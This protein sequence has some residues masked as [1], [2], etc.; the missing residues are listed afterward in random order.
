MTGHKRDAL[1]AAVAAAQRGWPVFP[2]ERGGKRPAVDRW[3]QRA[4]T[5]LEVIERAWSG[6]WSGYNIGIPSGRAGLAVLDLDCHAGLP[7]DWRAIPGVKDGAD[8]FACLLEWAGE[9]SWPATTWA[10]TPSGGYHLYLQQPPGQEIRNSAGL[11]GPGI[12]VRGTGGYVLAPGSVVG[13]RVYEL[14]DDTDPA[15]MPLWLARRLAPKPQDRPVMPEQ[16]RSLTAG[17]ARMRGLVEHV[18]HAQ[19]GDRNG[20]LFWAACRAGELVAAGEIDQPAAEQM[21]VLAALDAGLRGGEQEARR[22]IA[23]GLRTGGGR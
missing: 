5:D 3:E 8:V 9:S 23:S 6:Q 18:R 19:P 20:P 11:L 21:L 15:P 2:V 4:T 17:S 7:D 22:T 12:D 10:R 14:L 16:R 1:A 13:G